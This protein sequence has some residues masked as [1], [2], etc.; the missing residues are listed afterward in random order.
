MLVGSFD[1]TF[2]CAQL[3]D[4][5]TNSKEL[6][7]FL[8]YLVVLLN[9]KYPDLA[10][11][12]EE[13]AYSGPAS[14]VSLPTAEAEIAALRKGLG[15]LEGAL[16]K[17]DQVDQSDRFKKVMTISVSD[18]HTHSLYHFFLASLCP[19]RYIFALVTFRCRRCAA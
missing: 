16:A 5:K 15:S 12:P 2:L 7:T 14:K 18:S 8:H 13:I 1:L 19:L 4:T 11:W 9:D 6:P 3:V 10:K 17:V